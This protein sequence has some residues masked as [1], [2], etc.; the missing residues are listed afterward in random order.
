M[1]L[2]V[3]MAREAKAG[4]C[5]GLHQIER[6]WTKMSTIGEGGGLLDETSHRIKKALPAMLRQV[7]RSPRQV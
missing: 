3:W 5:R 2:Y 7:G 1:E 6:W 4:F